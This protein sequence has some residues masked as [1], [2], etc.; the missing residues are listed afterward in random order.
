MQSIPKLLD[1]LEV[2]S[3]AFRAAR[4]DHIIFN[5][6]GLPYVLLED[7]RAWLVSN[8][9]GDRP[10]VADVITALEEAFAAGDEDMRN[11]IAIALLEGLGNEG[12]ERTIRRLLG[13]QL[14]AQINR[15]DSW[16]PD[17]PI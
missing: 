9:D 3:P 12:G 15:M 17:A 6:E 4:A 16:S 5:G 7:F 13:P 11:L 2:I 14:R 10:Q 8:A 1:R